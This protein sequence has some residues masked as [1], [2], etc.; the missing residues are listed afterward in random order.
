MPAH[1][2]AQGHAC[3]P[4]GNFPAWRPAPRRGLCAALPRGPCAGAL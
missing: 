1:P 2:F 3:I 4:G